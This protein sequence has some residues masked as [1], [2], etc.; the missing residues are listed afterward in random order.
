MNWMKEQFERKLANVRAAYE[1]NALDMQARDQENT[2]FLIQSH[3]D[4]LREMKASFELR[5]RQL[6]QEIQDMRNA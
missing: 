6:L 2:A 3:S 1:Q 4:S 5:E